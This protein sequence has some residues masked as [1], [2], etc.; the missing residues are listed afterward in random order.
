MRRLKK[1]ETVNFELTRE[2]KNII[3]S[4]KKSCNK[5]E[6]RE[7]SVEHIGAS[8]LET[9]QLKPMKGNEKLGRILEY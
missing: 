2:R 3:M 9:Q 4:I 5:N 8:I 6:H 7:G 1:F